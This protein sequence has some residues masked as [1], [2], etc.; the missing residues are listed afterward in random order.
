MTEIKTATGIEKKNRKE[1]MV[2]TVTTGANAQLGLS[3][4]AITPSISIN[5]KPATAAI[6]I[7]AGG[8]ARMDPRPSTT[9]AEHF[10]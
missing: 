10:L 6:A 8:R 4:G 5:T 9:M 1:K 3:R 7:T 2:T